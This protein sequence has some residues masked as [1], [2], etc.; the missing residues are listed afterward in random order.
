M[1]I[2]GDQQAR[3]GDSGS[4]PTTE[5]IMNS[6]AGGERQAPL[7]P[8]E[9]TSGGADGVRADEPAGTTGTDEAEAVD[10]AGA[11]EGVDAGTEEPLL[12][13]TDTEEYRRRWSEV[14]GRF[15]D[16]PQDA[17]RS[18]DTLVAEVMQA[19]A[20]SFS[21]RKQGLEGQ[22]DRGEQVATEDLRVALQHYRSFFNRLLK[23]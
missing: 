7:Y 15:V 2:R 20:G 17:V 21:T 13:A 6:A 8:G 9:S 22:W 5:D 3:D 16:D 10:R 11:R 14:Q 12:G 1:R 19:L 18:A 4:G 23:T